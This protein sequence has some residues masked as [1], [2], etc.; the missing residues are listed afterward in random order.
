[1]L[2]GV[3][4]L[5]PTRPRGTEMHPQVSVNHLR[6]LSLGLRKPPRGFWEAPWGVPGDH[7]GSLVG[8]TGALGSDLDLPWHLW[9]R[10]GLGR[11]FCG[12]S[13]GSL[14]GHLLFRGA[15]AADVVRC[16]TAN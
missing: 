5:R 16:R 1:M 10:P 12:V 14:H 7:W 8:S 2:L 6:G 9:W 13:L 3:P 15:C 4:R 11:L